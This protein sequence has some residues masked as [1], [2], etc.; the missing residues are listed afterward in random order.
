MALLKDY[1]NITSGQIVNR[2][3]VNKDK[4]DK[5]VDKN[6]KVIVAKTISNGIIDDE[7]IDVM[8][9]KVQPDENKLTKEGDII[10][11]LSKPYGAALIDKDHEGM[12]ITSFCSV[13]R[14]VKGIDPGYLVAYLNSEV[15]DEKLTA[16]VAGSTMTIL[17][18]NKISELNIP[19]PSVEKQ[20][21]ISEFFKQSSKNKILFKK[22][23]KLENEKLSAL[24]EGLEE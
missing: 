5:I 23:V 19:V 12:L 8:D 7:S 14:N 18:N 21:E 20:K 1:I 13:I 17:S 22:I 15:A 2:V 11:K 9:L 6:R 4:G 3:Q 16:S 10:I 24:V